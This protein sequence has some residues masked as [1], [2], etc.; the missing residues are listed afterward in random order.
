MIKWNIIENGI[1]NT[2]KGGMT[3][4]NAQPYHRHFS[5]TLGHCVYRLTRYRLTLPRNFVCELLV[6]AHRETR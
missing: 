6:R 3:R 5:L 2:L 4:G 1:M